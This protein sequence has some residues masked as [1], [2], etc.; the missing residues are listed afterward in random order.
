LR[1]LGEG[2]LDAAV[3][4]LNLAGERSDGVARALREAGVP[5]VVSTGYA[6]G[7]DLP[8]E[9]QGVRR[10]SKPVRAASLAEALPALVGPPA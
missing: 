5:F 4:D 3:L 6:E 10:L 1:L 8:P 9:L 2:P 7:L